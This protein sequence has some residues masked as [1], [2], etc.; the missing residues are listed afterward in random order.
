[1]AWMQEKQKESNKPAKAQAADAEP[2]VQL[3]DLRVGKILK[4]ERHPNA[5]ALYVEQIDLGEA[6]PRQVYPMP[7]LCAQMQPCIVECF[8]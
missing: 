7:T 8:E 3:L 2:S 4:I 6:Q 1:M 5:E